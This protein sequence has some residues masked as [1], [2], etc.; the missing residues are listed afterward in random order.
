MEQETDQEQEQDS[1]QTQQEQTQPTETNEPAE[2]NE[3]N[4]EVRW[5]LTNLPEEEQNR[6]QQRMD[7]DTTTYQGPDVRK[8]M[9]VTERID[10]EELPRQQEDD[11]RQES[12]PQRPRRSARPRIEFDIAKHNLATKR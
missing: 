4:K 3:N 6:E 9:Q 7:Q 12:R 11:T 8:E 1:E 2:D 10:T 5:D